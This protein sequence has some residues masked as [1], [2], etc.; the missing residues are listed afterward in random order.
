MYLIV[1]KHILITNV[2]DFGIFQS[3]LICG[4]HQHSTRARWHTDR[5]F[6]VVKK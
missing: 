4:I 5:L 3:M 6:S 1:I 2:F